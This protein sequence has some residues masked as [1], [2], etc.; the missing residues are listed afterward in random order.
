MQINDSLVA[1]RRLARQARQ[2]F[3]EGLCTSLPD[4]DKT[5]TEFLS[6]LLAQ[7]GTQR[8]MQTRRDAWLLYQQH[9]T[10][11]LERTAKTWRDALVPYSSSSQG[12]AVLSS[13]FELLCDDVVENKIVAARMALTVAEQVSPQ[14]DSLRQRQQQ[15]I[16]QIVPQH[17]VPPLVHLLTHQ[18]PEPIQIRQRRHQHARQ[19]LPR[20]HRQRRA[21]TPAGQNVSGNLHGNRGRES[22]TG[23]AAKTADRF[24]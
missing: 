14:F 23:R 18:P 17:M 12:Q 4:L 8:E 15:P 20:P 5:V 1:Q 13:Q 16:G 7:T 24:L 10:A 22:V 3:V 2:R 9:H 19:P 11:W 21:D 6:A